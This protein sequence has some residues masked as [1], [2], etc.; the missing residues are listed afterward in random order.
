MKLVLDLRPENVD[1]D[2]KTF[3]NMIEYEYFVFKGGE[4]HIKLKNV[5]CDS[6]DVIEV[7]AR[8]DSFEAVGKLLI[9]MNALKIKLNDSCT[10]YPRL[11]LVID[12]FPGARQDRVMVSGEP[13]TAKVYAELINN[14]NFDMVIISDAHS[15]VTPALLN[16]CLNKDNHAFVYSVIRNIDPS[17]ESK[18]LLISPDA[19]A[20]K[21][22]GSLAKYISR[23]NP[24]EVIKCDKTR[25]ITTGDITDFE[26]YADDLDG[27]DCLIVDDICDGG[28]T[29]LGLASKLK[30]KGAG[31]LYLAVT[32]GIFSAGFKALNETFEMV[33][34]TNS[35]KEY[36]KTWR[37]AHHHH[38]GF[39]PK[40]I[41]L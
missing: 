5:Y 13:F 27:R 18:F 34:T 16:N 29:F 24:I 22:I 2:Y 30:E 11:S 21:K 6:G 33:Y 31:K 17:L 15:D 1:K 19:G 37:E 41:Q 4:P 14:L 39:S 10:S 8:L 40:L 38:L 23:F 20:N 26:V 12:Y 28:G 9:A 36:D 35:F 3:H 25:D 32:H 7:I